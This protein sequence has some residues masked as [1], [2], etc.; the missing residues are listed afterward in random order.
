MK[1]KVSYYFNADTALEVGVNEA[2]ILTAIGGWVNKNAAN[3]QNF[4]DGKNWTYNSFAGWQKLFP[5]WSIATIRRALDK[6]EAAGYI[7]TSQPRKKSRDQTKWYTVTERGEKA[8]NSPFAQNEQIHLLKMSKSICSKC[9][10]PS[11]QNEQMNNIITHNNIHNIPALA[12]VE[13]YVSDNKL[14]IDARYFWQF[15][16]ASGWTSKG[17]PIKN[18]KQKAL[19]WNRKNAE[20]EKAQAVIQDNAAPTKQVLSDEQKQRDFERRMKE[21]GEL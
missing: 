18:W 19:T 5:F 6:L 4:H 10:N 16:E 9:T 13:K 11:A 15:Y 20:R 17:E 3:G 7:I 12:D 2:I 21:L 8:L 1:V 14:N